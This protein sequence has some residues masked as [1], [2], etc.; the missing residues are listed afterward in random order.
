MTERIK[1]ISSLIAREISSR[2]K[3][4]APVNRCLDLFC[5]ITMSENV[6]ALPH[7]RSMN[8]G[9]INSIAATFST[10][11]SPKHDRF[12]LLKHQGSES[13]IMMTFH[14]HY[15]LSKLRPL[16]FFPIRPTFHAI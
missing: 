4:E 11:I 1:E 2:F 15:T 16:L 9:I 8:A 12:Q 10:R 6:L 14:L 5:V 3:D 13:S 7:R